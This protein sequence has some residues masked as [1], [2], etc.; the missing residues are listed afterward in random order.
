MARLGLLDGLK[1]WQVLTGGDELVLG[2]FTI[3]KGNDPWL[4]GDT[5]ISNE[6]YYKWCFTSDRYRF[7]VKCSD[8]ITYA[9]E[10]GG[11]T[12]I[13]IIEATYQGYQLTEVQGK[14]NSIIPNLNL[15][16]VKARV[17]Q[18]FKNNPMPELVA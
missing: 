10:G 4:L 3:K 2:K 5:V 8:V 17:V 1:R 11:T 7:T 12:N 18:W 6:L 14:L 9:I 15:D 16:R 13:L